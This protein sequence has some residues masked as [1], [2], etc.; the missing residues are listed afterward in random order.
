MTDQELQLWLES[1]NQECATIA[2]RIANGLIECNDPRGI[3][4]VVSEMLGFCERI[5]EEISM[6]EELGIEQDSAALKEAIQ[7]LELVV[8][9]YSKTYWN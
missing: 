5:K 8:A 9:R 4:V 7:D 6:C 3:Q 2:S 1:L